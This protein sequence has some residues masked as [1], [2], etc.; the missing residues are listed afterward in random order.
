M[1]NSV[2]KNEIVSIEL[3]APNGWNIF[4]K[5]L[6]KKGGTP[7]KNEIIFTAPTGEEITTRKQL[8]QYLKSHPGGPPV[9]EFDWGTGET[10]RRS[11]R[12]TEKVKA[13]Q[14]PAG[15]EPAKKRSR[16][17][18]A[19]KKDSK[20]VTEEIDAAKD[21]DIEE[22]EKHEK[23]T[24]AMEAEKDV[25]Q[26]Q[27]GKSEEEKKE[28]AEAT[29][30]DVQKKN[31]SENADGK[32]EDAPSEEAQV[33][34]DVEMADNVGHTDDVE[35]APADK[36]ADGPVATKNNDEEIDINVQEVENTAKST[37]EAQIEK[38]VKMTDNIGHPDDVEEAPADKAADGPEATKNNEE[39]K[40][41]QVQEVENI[42][43]EE[44]QVEKDVK[45]ADNDVEAAPADKAAD[46]SEATK[47][48]EEEKAVPV[49]VVEKIPTEET[50]VEKDVKMADNVRHPNDVE[51]APADKAAEEKDVQVQGVE[52]IPTE[53]ERLD[54]SVAEEKKHQGEGEQKDEQKTSAAA[55]STE[56]QVNLKNIEIS[57]VEG[58]VTE[59]G[60][61]A[62]EAKP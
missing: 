57:K 56:D 44:A 39:E 27:D 18:S 41:V 38:D 29:E 28:E 20:E 59:N 35:K 23:D 42:P 50:H 62:N 19:S 10:P 1:A 61:K 49:Q 21:D 9:A 8:E 48:N 55:K 43:T 52:N 11:A 6:P 31:E 32:V 45:M 12:I 3:P 25:E 16:K 13:T 24:A 46:G 17:S 5:F 33:E 58:E 36:A 30:K 4:L 47:N 60:S 7:K 37:E 26:K 2:E 53:A 22:T 34:K 51:D 15:S 40:N 14:S 54:S